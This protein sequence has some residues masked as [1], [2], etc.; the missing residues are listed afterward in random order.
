MTR[1]RWRLFG[2]AGESVSDPLAARGNIVA[3]GAG[4][5]APAVV[6]D[7][8]AAASGLSSSAVGLRGSLAGYGAG[9][10]ASGALA[11]RWWVRRL[12][13]DSP[14]GGFRGRATLAADR[15]RETPLERPAAA[16]GGAMATAAATEPAAGAAAAVDV[17]AAAAPLSDGRVR[18][19]ASASAP[20][21]PCCFPGLAAAPDR[22]AD[23]PTLAA[24][25]LA[26]AVPTAPSDTDGAFPRGAGGA[27]ATM[28]A[29]RTALRMRMT[30]RRC[31]LV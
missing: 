18:S 5:A 28:P 17:V 15:E 11:C 27:S 7:L 22:W 10:W 25:L 2:C 8:P 6:P 14:T 26:L 20:A 13:R 12:E 1:R 9:G 4:V 30:C 23:W 19:S 24:R 29:R 21:C 16:A 31:W 3:T